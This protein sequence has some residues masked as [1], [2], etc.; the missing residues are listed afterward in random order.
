[1]IIIYLLGTS[2]K[3]RTVWCTTTWTE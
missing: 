1:M 2:W 3:Q